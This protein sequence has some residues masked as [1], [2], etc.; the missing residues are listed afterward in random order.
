MLDVVWTGVRYPSSI[1]HEPIE[2]TV[3]HRLVLPFKTIACPDAT[4]DLEF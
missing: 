2:H 3:A 4:Q 1:V